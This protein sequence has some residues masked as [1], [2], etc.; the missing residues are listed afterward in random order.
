MRIA[1]MVISLC[2]TMIVGLQSCAVMV[3]GKMTQDASLSGSGS[4]GVLIA[5]L[6]VIGAGFAIALPKV[7]MIVFGAA[8][9]LGIMA[10]GNS[11][12][13]DMYIWGGVAL[14]LSV[15]SYFGTKELDRKK[16]KPAAAAPANQPAPTDGGEA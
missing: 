16:G 7:S 9:L 13:H 1:V 6:F 8:A 12:Y 14:V 10:G 11:T 3:G 4:V 5:L 2:L 15:M